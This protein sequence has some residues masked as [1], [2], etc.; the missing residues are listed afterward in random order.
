VFG[1]TSGIEQLPLPENLLSQAHV[2]GATDLSYGAPE[3]ALRK[4]RQG[5]SMNGWET[6]RNS[7]RQRLGME[8]FFFFC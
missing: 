4:N 8:F 5:L 7:Y 3:L 1:D 2:F 6:C